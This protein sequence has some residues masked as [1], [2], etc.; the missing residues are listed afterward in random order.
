MRLLMICYSTLL[1]SCSL[2]NRTGPDVSCADLQNGAINACKDG[3]IASCISGQVTYQVCTDSSDCDQ[4]WQTPGAYVCGS[5]QSDN[6][7]AT[8]TSTT[9][10]TT[11]S[12]STSSTTS[13]SSVI[14]ALTPIASSSGCYEI[15]VT[16]GG[17]PVSN[18]TVTINVACSDMEL[19]FFG[20]NWL[21]CSGCSTG[22][23]ARQA[24]ATS[25]AL[26]SPVTDF[27]TS[28]SQTPQVISHSP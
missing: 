28:S 3:I 7:S 4:S 10:Q 20:S 27:C 17:S 18:W 19:V 26:S 11:S 9:S 15:H 23:Y 24:T 16:S 12:Q 25:T 6:S 8:S 5:I 13:N 14:V 22:C 1:V 2:L 21:S